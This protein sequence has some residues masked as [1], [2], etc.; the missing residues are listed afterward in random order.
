MPDRLRIPDRYRRALI[1]GGLLLAFLLCLQGTPAPDSFRFAILGD[2]TGEAQPGVYEQVW[3]E[4]AAENP[5]FVLSVGDTIQGMDDAVAEAEWREIEGMLRPYRRYPLYLV[6][7]NHDIWSA[8]SERLFQRHAGHAAHYSFDYGQAHVTVLDNSRS[9]EL[10]A[11]ELAFLEADLKAHAGQPVKMIVSHRPSW[12]VN[13]ALGNP[14]FE[15]HQLARRSGVQYAIAGHVHQM[16]RLSLDG[17]TY[18][19]MASSGGHL[20]LSRAYEDG[21][22]FGYAL[23]EV[24]GGSAEFRIKELSSPHGE[25]RITKLTNWGMT[26]L[27]QR[28]RQETAPVK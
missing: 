2:R 19:S 12:L 3:K 20:R 4:V 17:V 7:G 6:P 15:L 25:G 28:D 13:V 8:E 11:G 1:L 16:L 27:I 24:H 23:V 26:G 21:W 5:A 22:F 18:V 10:A 9:D 14:K